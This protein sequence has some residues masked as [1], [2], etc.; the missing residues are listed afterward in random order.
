MRNGLIGLIQAARNFDTSKGMAFS[1]FAVT[2][3][4]NSI[5][6]EMRRQRAEFRKSNDNVLYFSSSYA[7]D[8][9]GATLENI[10]PDRVQYGGVHRKRR[11]KNFA[12]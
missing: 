5:N 7:D 9:D 10:I 8:D 1:T 4:R 12:I 2:C 6:L 11:R 3:I